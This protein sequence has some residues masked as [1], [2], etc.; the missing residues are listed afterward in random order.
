MESKEILKN[1]IEDDGSCDWIISTAGDKDHPCDFCPLSER[2]L[3]DEGEHV[4]CT[5]Y[6]EIKTGGT[7]DQDYLEV[8]IKILTELEIEDIILDGKNNHT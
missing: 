3:D 7:T 4:G 8:A 5:R 1:I 6:V 2:A